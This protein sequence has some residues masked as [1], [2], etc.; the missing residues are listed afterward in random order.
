MQNKFQIEDIP[1]TQHLRTFGQEKRENLIKNKDILMAVDEK[2][3]VGNVSCDFEICV[4]LV[5]PETFTVLVW[6]CPGCTFS[7][8]IS[9]SISSVDPGYII[10]ILFRFIKYSLCG[11]D[12]IDS[13]IT[14]IIFSVGR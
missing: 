6:L 14:V 13:L 2:C 3:G 12:H 7:I 9:R 8:L 10:S 11:H 5:Y 1:F 4:K